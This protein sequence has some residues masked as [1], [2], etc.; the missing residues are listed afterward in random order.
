M[1]IPKPWRVALFVPVLL[2]GALLIA[3]AFVTPFRSETARGKVVAILASRLQADVELS[4]L[5]LQVLPRFRAEGHGLRIRHHGR[6]D[7]PPMIEIKDF[8]AEGSLL[9]VLRRHISRVVIDRLDL[10]QI[11]RLEGYEFVGHRIVQLAVVN[12]FWVPISVV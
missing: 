3:M 1:R 2:F 6:R 8:S 4:D 5:R 12:R 10:P 9:G 11:E 7:V